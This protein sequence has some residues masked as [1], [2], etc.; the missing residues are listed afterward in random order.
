MTSA[1]CCCRCVWI[2][3]SIAHRATSHCISLTAPLQ[4]ENARR[5]RS[6]GRRCNR[7]VTARMV[8]TANLLG[9]GVGLGLGL[10]LG[11]GFYGVSS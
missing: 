5:R 1:I 11:S 3:V 9:L 7:S 8:C 4:D 6:E 10:G 2:R